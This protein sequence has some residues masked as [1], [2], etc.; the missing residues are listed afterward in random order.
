MDHNADFFPPLLPLQQNPFPWRKF[1]IN[2]G[3]VG[4][5]NYR[6]SGQ[7]DGG[8][9]RQSCRAGRKVKRNGVNFVAQHATVQH[10]AVVGIEGQEIA[11]DKAFACLAQGDKGFVKMQHRCWVV[12]L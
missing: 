10:Q 7:A 5:G 4:V 9:F 6:R 3:A 8:L 11:V 12:F 2:D 1:P